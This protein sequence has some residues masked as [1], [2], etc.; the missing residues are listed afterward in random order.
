MTDPQPTAGDARPQAPTTSGLLPQTHP[1]SHP[2]EPTAMSTPQPVPAV[3]TALMLGNTLGPYRLLALLGHGGMGAVYKAQ[4]EHL[5]KT[6]A[7][8]VLPQHITKHPESIARFKREMKAVGKLNH[9]I[10][11]HR[12][13][14][15]R[16]NL[17]IWLGLVRAAT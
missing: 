15:A 4:H 3:E 2:G 9:S 17:Q 10:S 14:A 7:I 5:D 1:S 13:A 11:C 8:K 16:P 6:V 12:H